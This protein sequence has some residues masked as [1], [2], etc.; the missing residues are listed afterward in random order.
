MPAKDLQETTVAGAIQT[1]VYQAPLL[2]KAFAQPLTVVIMTKR[3]LRTHGRAH[4][5]LLSRDLTL[6]YAPRVDDDSVRF[7]I[8]CNFRDAKPYWGLEDF[9]HVTPTGVTHAA[10]LSLCMVNVASQLQADG[11]QRDPDYRILDLKADG[12][13]STYVEETINMLPE[14]PEPV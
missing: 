10:H 6:A 4:V 8:E 1:R 12:R 13:G 14:T 7:P 5:I 11:R 3:H 9:M 2:H